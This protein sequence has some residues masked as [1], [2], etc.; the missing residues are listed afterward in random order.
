LV[1][2]TLVVKTTTLDML[3]YT[4]R[5]SNTST[6]TST[7]KLPNT[8]TANPTNTITPIPP[9]STST[10]TAI[11][12]VDVTEFVPSG[13]CGALQDKRIFT[14]A[15]D[16]DTEFTYGYYPITET[17]TGDITFL[18]LRGPKHNITTEEE[19]GATPPINFDNTFWE[20]N[21]IRKIAESPE[22]AGY[23]SPSGRFVIYNVWYGS[24]FDADSK[25]EIWVAETKGQKKWK[26]HE[27]GYSSVYIYRAAW[28]D[29]E[30]KVIFNTT[31]EGPTEFFI[32][33]FQTGVTSSLSE[34]TE[35]SGITEETW[36]L[37]PDGNILAVVD[38]TGQLLLVSLDTGQVKIV[39]RVGGS[40]PQWS[41]DGKFLFYWWR[42]E[43]NWMGDIRE[44][45][46]YSLQKDEITPIIDDYSLR[47][48][49]QDYLGDDICFYKDYY[50]SGGR[51]SV[52]PNH[53]NILLWDFWLYVIE[54]K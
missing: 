4:A 2:D 10:P 19:M 42:G 49:F 34:S 52:S 18:D 13:R 33:E 28:F 31:Y 41:G 1:E 48:G 43:N 37:S 35:F 54:I 47:I 29:N 39:E 53:Q 24:V 50:L 25:T 8:P 26:I 12:K 23:F 40:F 22:L 51:Y 5:P 45:R 17:I 3:E 15:W 21:G 44:L 38:L 32:S 36:R 6:P 11:W 30:S 46:S 9:T 20:R 16:N 7:I 14:V 27:F